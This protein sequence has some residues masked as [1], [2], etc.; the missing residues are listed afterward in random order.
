LVWDREFQSQEN[1]LTSLESTLVAQKS[2]VQQSAQPAFDEADELARAASLVVEQLKDEHNPKFQKSEFMGL[3]RQ[4]RDREMVLD[5]SAIVQ[6]D[7]ASSEGRAAASA[8]GK[9]KAVEMT[10]QRRADILNTGPA[11]QRH[12][13]A[14]FAA[15]SDGPIME[16]VRE[17]L[18]TQAKD[19]ATQGQ[20]VQDDNDIYFQ[21]EN[22]DYIRYWSGS[23]VDR[24]TRSSA[25]S[26]LQDSWD[27]FEATTAGI[28]P[29][30]E[31]QFQP[32]NPYLFGQSS[33]TRNHIIHSHKLQTFKE[34]FFFR[35]FSV[36]K[37]D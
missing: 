1:T 16:A 4:L 18:D 29:V 11:H 27:Q 13:Q 24:R 6:W 34:V 14:P 12:F 21:Q 22:E 3:M 31:Y 20:S 19:E 5:G 25:W 7:L 37:S 8:K 23:R 10:Q 15:L 17:E 35:F 36:T 2:E 33:R 26:E 28:K 9:G 32:N 30:E